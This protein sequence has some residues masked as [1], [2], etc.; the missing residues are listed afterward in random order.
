MKIKSIINGTF[1]TFTAEKITKSSLTSKFKCFLTH[2]I[3]LM[4]FRRIDARSVIPLFPCEEIQLMKSV[5]D[6]TARRAF[7]NSFCSRPI[8]TLAV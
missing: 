1:K 8:L 7:N 3:Q 2:L 5:F 4:G 6:A